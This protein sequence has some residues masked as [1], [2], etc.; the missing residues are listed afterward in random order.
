MQR[1][2]QAHAVRLKEAATSTTCCGAVVQ[3]AA[4]KADQSKL[5]D[6]QQQEAQMDTAAEQVTTQVEQ[7]AAQMQDLKK[8]VSQDQGASGLC[9]IRVKHT[10]DHTQF[11][12]EP[13][14]LGGLQCRLNP[15]VM[16]ALQYVCATLIRKMSGLGGPWVA[17]VICS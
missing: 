4:L 14:G 9:C 17:E 1:S 15:R 13:Q 10:W 7:L 12:R 5:S 11:C 3:Q 16:S 8:Q 6:L 2:F